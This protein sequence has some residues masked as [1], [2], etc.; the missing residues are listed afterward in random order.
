MA[1]WIM[2]IRPGPSR[3]VRFPYKP[4]AHDAAYSLSTFRMQTTNGKQRVVAM[5]IGIANLIETGLP[6]QRPANNAT[7][8][9]GSSGLAGNPR[10]HPKPTPIHRAR[11]IGQRLYDGVEYQRCGNQNCRAKRPNLSSC[12]E[13]EID[14]LFVCDASSFPQSLARP[15]VLILRA[16]GQ[17]LA[18][19]L[20]T[21]KTQKRDAA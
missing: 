5:R 1:G 6:H 11:Q 19:Y 14:N 13:T 8:K 10:G 9:K 16:L 4:Q 15:T 17:R 2:I 20:P 7:P 3:L 18:D 21:R 12:L